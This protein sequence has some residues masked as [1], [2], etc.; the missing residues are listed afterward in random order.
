MEIYVISRAMQKYIKLTLGARSHKTV[1][2]WRK[3]P[4]V[5]AVRFHF[6]Q[7]TVIVF[8]EKEITN[9]IEVAADMDELKSPVSE[10]EKI[11]SNLNKIAKYFNTGGERSPAI[12]DEIRQCI[13][14]L[15]YLLLL[16]SYAS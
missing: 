4:F 12:E 15:F 7:Q 5:W 16:N 9:I 13:S 8:L 1:F 10:Y 2:C 6:F 14:N 3:Q 11:G